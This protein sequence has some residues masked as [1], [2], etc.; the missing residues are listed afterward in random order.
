MPNCKWNLQKQTGPPSEIRGGP[1]SFSIAGETMKPKGH[2]EINWPLF[3]VKKD[4][5]NKQTRLKKAFE[6]YHLFLVKTCG[7][8]LAQII[9]CNGKVW[10]HWD[11]LIRNFIWKEHPLKYVLTYIGMTSDVFRLGMYFR[12]FLNQ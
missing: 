9:V 6:N 4:R 12:I 5:K 1:G 2:Y 10:Q 3:H 11:I 8:Q 7:E